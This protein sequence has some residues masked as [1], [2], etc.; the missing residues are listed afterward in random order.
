MYSFN[1]EFCPTVID[2][3]LSTDNILQSNWERSE[4]YFIAILKI[5]RSRICSDLSFCNFELQRNLLL[6]N[7]ESL[8]QRSYVTLRYFYTQLSRDEGDKC[9]G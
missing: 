5:F 7:K 4:F 2:I 1:L 8:Y 3:L 9:R 6:G